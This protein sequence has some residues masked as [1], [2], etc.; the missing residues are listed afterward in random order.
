M[1][2]LRVCLLPSHALSSPISARGRIIAAAGGVEARSASTSSAAPLEV[3]L[4]PCLEDNYGFLVHDRLS[5]DTAAVDTPDAAALQA[6]LADRG[7][8]LTTVLNTHHHAD[9][10]GGNLAL[11]A[12]AAAA[13]RS[14]RGLTVYG[15]EREKARIPGLDV[16]VAGGD[17]FAWGGN[18]NHAVEVTG[19]NPTRRPCPSSQR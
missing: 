15:P 4:V 11:K 18:G 1:R 8:T 14:P 9:H 2:L 16:G 5:G 3:T 13:T 10:T 6:A 12:A 7:W 17:S 19:P